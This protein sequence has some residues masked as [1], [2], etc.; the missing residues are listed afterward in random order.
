MVIEVFSSAL[1]FPATV[2]IPPTYSFLSQPT[3]LVL[4]CGLDSI[5]FWIHLSGLCVNTWPIHCHFMLATDSTTSI[6]SVLSR[7][8]IFRILFLKMTTSI[9]LSMALYVTLSCFATSWVIG[10]VFKLEVK[11][12]WM[13]RPYAL[14]FR[15]IGT[16]WLFYWNFLWHFGIIEALSNQWPNNFSPSFRKWLFGLFLRTWF[17]E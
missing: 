16:S 15:S 8:W 4:P 13:Q 6:T 9:I 11:T 3:L 12:G 14:L 1:C 2:L 17:F 7:L 5:T 10:V